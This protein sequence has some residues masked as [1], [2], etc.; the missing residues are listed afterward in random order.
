MSSQRFQF[1]GVVS[2]AVAL[3]DPAG[4]Q[5]TISRDKI[6]T[7]EAQIAALQQ[8]VRAR[9]SQANNTEKKAEKAY[10]AATPAVKPPP[11]PPPTAVVRMSPGNRP[12][13]CT[14]DGLNC[15]GLT[16]R[17]HFDAGGYDYRPNTAGTAI[18]HL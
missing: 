18:R 17:L 2:V 3:V 12:S 10:A 8:E 11:A 4:A 15:V 6:D 7:L 14:A 16:A 1:V 9:K 5:T 13:I